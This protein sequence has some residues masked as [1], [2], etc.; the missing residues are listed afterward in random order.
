MKF[1]VEWELHVTTHSRTTKAPKALKTLMICLETG[2]RY[3]NMP[4]R[5]ENQALC[6]K[7]A[8]QSLPGLNHALP[9]LAVLCYAV[10]LCG[11]N[12]LEELQASNL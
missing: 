2:L 10:L 11:G 3:G 5:R 4:L 9:R 12:E 1:V 8:G 6:K 7:K